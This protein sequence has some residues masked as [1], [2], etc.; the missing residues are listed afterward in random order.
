MSTLY[1]NKTAVDCARS[2]LAYKPGSLLS[3]VNW[4]Q[5]EDPHWFGGRI[6]QAVQSVEMLLIKAEGELSYRYYDGPSLVR[7]EVPGGIY[8]Q[9]VGFITAQ[10]ASVVPIGAIDYQPK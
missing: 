7:K 10:K 2:G 3:L 5:R 6:P 4:T 8:E 1:G 9:R